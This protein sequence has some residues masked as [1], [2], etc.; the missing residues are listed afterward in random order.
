MRVS[1]RSIPRCN[2]SRSDLMSTSNRLTVAAQPNR[3]GEKQSRDHQAKPQTR[4]A[5]EFGKIQLLQPDHGKLRSYFDHAVRND[6]TW[7]RSCESG[8]KASEQPVRH[9]RAEIVR[10]E[11]D[12][13]DYAERH[14]RE[15]R[16]K[17]RRALGP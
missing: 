2:P 5:Q 8:V 4:T 17:E 13:F 14:R 3:A 11:G 7:L 15:H 12:A 6:R 9:Q 10:I 16:P 1:I